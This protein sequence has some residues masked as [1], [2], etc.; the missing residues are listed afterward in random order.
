[1]KT[2]LFLIGFIGLYFAID[3][4]GHVIS[5][6]LGPVAIA[7]FVGALL[8]GMLRLARSEK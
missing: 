1:M 2:V 6:V 5:P 8:G 4:Y 7:S 3:L